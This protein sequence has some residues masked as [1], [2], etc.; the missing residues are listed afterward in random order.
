MYA[1]SAGRL[2]AKIA[3]KDSLA[4]KLA[5]RPDRQE[6]INRNI[7]PAQS[8]KERQETKEAVGARL[9]RYV[10]WME[11]PRREDAFTLHVYA[12]GFCLQAAE[13]ETNARRIG[14]AQHFEE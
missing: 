7:L 8:E 11:R 13:Y 2:A 12:S 1:R 6:L 10:R 9:I 5:L 14:R 3:R 4:I